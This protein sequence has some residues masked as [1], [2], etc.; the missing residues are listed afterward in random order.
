MRLY[1]SHNSKMLLDSGVLMKIASRSKF[2]VASTY[3]T[4]AGA[5]LG[6]QNCGF[7]SGFEKFVGAILQIL[8]VQKDF[9]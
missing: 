1:Q 2:V 8:R 9:S 4:F 6:I 7:K 5:G 3:P